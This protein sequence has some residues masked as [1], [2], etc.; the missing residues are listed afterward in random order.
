MLCGWFWQLWEVGPSITALYTDDT[1]WGQE[2]LKAG[3]PFQPEELLPP[4]R[5]GVIDSFGCIL[6]FEVVFD[7]SDWSAKDLER[8][9]PAD[10]L[11]YILEVVSLV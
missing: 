8:V 5:P 2:G 1:E 4:S 11:G 6:G 3:V 10:L 7:D 9:G